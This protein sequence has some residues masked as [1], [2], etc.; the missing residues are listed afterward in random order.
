MG[1]VVEIDLVVALP[2]QRKSET[3]TTQATSPTPAPG[4]IAM[5]ESK[6]RMEADMLFPAKHERFGRPEPA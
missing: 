4:D 2:G 5:L 1:R 3:G 6:V